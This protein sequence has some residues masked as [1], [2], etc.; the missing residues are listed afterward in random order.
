MPNLPP[1][2]IA[3]LNKFTNRGSNFTY[4]KIPEAKEIVNK[5][6]VPPVFSEII[7]SY[8]SLKNECQEKEKCDQVEMNLNKTNLGITEN[9]IDK[10]KFA[11]SVTLESLQNK[12]EKKHQS[13]KELKEDEK[14]MLK[15]LK[16]DEKPKIVELTNYKDVSVKK[17]QKS[18]SKLIQKRQDYSHLIYPE[19]IQIPRDK[20]K[21]GYTYKLN[22]CYYH[23]DGSFLYRVPGME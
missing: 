18:D 21:E 12:L 19:R 20:F 15:N 8:E 10:R 17:F 11:S 1:Q 2:L 22:D 4:I 14:L 5:R 3:H 7:T 6:K 9:I 23:S 16:V 13:G